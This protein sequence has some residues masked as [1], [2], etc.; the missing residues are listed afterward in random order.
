M[1]AGIRHRTLAELRRLFG[2]AHLADAEPEAIAG[3]AATNGHRRC[4]WH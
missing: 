3:V 1:L 2:A 4:K